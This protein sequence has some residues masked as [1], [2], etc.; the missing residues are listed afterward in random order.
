MLY[1]IEF[2]GNFFNLEMQSF[3]LIFIK[4][5]PVWSIDGLEN[6]SQISYQ[7]RFGSPNILAISVE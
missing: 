3:L 1:Q 6:E 4:W 2:Q 7:I 5:Y